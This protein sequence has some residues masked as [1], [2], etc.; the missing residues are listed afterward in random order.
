MTISNNNPHPDAIVMTDAL[1]SD[2]MVVVHRDATGEPY[3]FH[4][5]LASGPVHCALCE[6]PGTRVAMVIEGDD[7]EPDFC[8]NA[9]KYVDGIMQPCENCGS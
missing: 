8:M 1:G 7:A 9:H 2:R 3:C 5:P 6:T 4:S